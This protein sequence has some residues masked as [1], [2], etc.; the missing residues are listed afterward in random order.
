[1]KGGQLGLFL[2]ISLLSIFELVEILIDF[3]V[4]GFFQASKKEEKKKPEA[5]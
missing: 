3:M 1:M 5:F 4:K 2:G